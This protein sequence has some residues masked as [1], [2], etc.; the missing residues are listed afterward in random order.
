MT[1][2]DCTFTKNYSIE[3]G[4]AVYNRHSALNIN[5]CILPDNYSDGRAGAIY[6]YS[7]SLTI[8]NSVFDHNRA[9]DSGAIYLHVESTLKILKNMGHGGAMFEDPLVTAL[10]V[11]F[12]DKH[13]KAE[14]KEKAG[15]KQNDKEK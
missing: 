7:N 5:N 6:G 11:E 15:K 8:I 14:E 3:D 13:L 2:T 9:L 4:G 1:L 10:I 12:F